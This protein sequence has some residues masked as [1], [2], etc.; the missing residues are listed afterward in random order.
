MVEF[1]GSVDLNLGVVYFFVRWSKTF[2]IHICLIQSMAIGGGWWMNDRTMSLVWCTRVCALWQFN[3]LEPLCC[4]FNASK[5]GSN[6]LGNL[7]EEDIRV[8][9]DDTILRKWKKLPRENDPWL[10]IPGNLIAFYIIS[11]EDKFNNYF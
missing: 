4:T 8:G 3:M 5:I 9:K 10:I 2:L 11:F 6:F 1:L 7:L